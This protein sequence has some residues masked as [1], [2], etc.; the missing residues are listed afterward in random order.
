[1]TV[2]MAAPAAFATAAV[3]TVAPIAVLMMA[4]I[5]YL[6]VITLRWARS[7]VKQEHDR[8][9]DKSPWGFVGPVRSNLE[10]QTRLLYKHIMSLG[11]SP[12]T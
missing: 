3:L 12:V 11:N 9:W 2:P 7:P 5:V 8:I 10:M 1:M 4:C 6:P